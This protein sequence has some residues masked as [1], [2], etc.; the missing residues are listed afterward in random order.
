MRSQTMGKTC[1]RTEPTWNLKTENFWNSFENFEIFSSYFV[2]LDIQ[3]LFRE[4]FGSFY[5][6]T[7][8]IWFIF[9]SLSLENQGLVNA[10]KSDARTGG[11]IVFSMSSNFLI[12]RVFVI[13]VLRVDKNNVWPNT[14]FSTCSWIQRFVRDD[15]YENISTLRVS[16]NSKKF[17]SMNLE[18]ACWDPIFSTHPTPHTHR[19]P[20]KFTERYVLSKG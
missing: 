2:F 15:V 7:L 11:K 20:H 12:N 10:S 17:S 3:R 1:D 5:R 19:L 8:G 13:C 16:N 4:F 14:T 18:A 6:D 9:P